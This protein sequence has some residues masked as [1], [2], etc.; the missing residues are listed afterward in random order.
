MKIILDSHTIKKYYDIS[1]AS[2]LRA[3]AYEDFATSQDVKVNGCSTLVVHG[4]HITLKPK[5]G[6]F[7]CQLLQQAI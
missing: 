5:F 3:V 4:T 1:L 6:F 7:L 2:A